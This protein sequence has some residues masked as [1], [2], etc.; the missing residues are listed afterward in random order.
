MVIKGYDVWP[1]LKKTG[2]EIGEDRVTIY[3]AQMAYTLFFSLFPLILF[4]AA[5]FSLIADRQTVMGWIS[6]NAGAA[7]PPD[8]A[9]L[10]QKTME[11]VVSVNGA[12][13]ILSFGLLT[14]LW[15]GSAIFG[16]MTTA[17]NAAYDVAESRPWWKKQ[18]VRLAAR[19]VTGIVILAASLILLNGEGIVRWI[20][21]LVGLGETARTLW[22]ILQIP[23]A[24]GL[25]VLSIA[26][27]YYFLPNTGPQ[28]RSIVLLCA[29]LTT[30]LWIAATIGFRFYVQNFHAVNPAY[31]AIG[32]V[33]VLLTWMFYSMFVF[34]AVGELNSELQAG[35]ARVGAKASEPPPREAAKARSAAGQKEVPRDRA[36]VPLAAQ[37]RVHAE[38]AASVPMTIEPVS[39]G[40]ASGDGDGAHRATPRPLTTRELSSR[41]L[42]SFIRELTGNAARLVRREVALARIEAAAIFRAVGAGTMLMA[43]GFVVGLLG[44]L[45]LVSSMVLVVGDQWLPEDLYWVSALVVTIVTA[46]VASVFLRRGMNALAPR[47]MLHET[48]RTVADD[49]AWA[50]GELEA[51]RE[52]ARAAVER[53]GPRASAS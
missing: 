6:G 8:V 23:L 42:I 49:R 21:G 12:P 14:V 29:L 41:S 2:K 1:L 48:R 44:L 25:V 52:R 37:E 10:L 11:S 31:G 15:S 43:G 7:L 45:T 4:A 17:L 30:V 53:E 46:V 34:L 50:E 20:G 35:T 24:I 26:L 51:L 36:L 16:S 28:D 47:A 13:G 5:V 9:G 39:V 19:V 38:L 22:A 40:A 3:A 32:A 27:I 18:L 33:M